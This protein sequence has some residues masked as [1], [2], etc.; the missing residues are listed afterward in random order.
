MY[1][2]MYLALFNQAWGLYGKILTEVMSEYR[3]NEVRSVHTTEVKI[4][5]YRLTKFGK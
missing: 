2:Q 3:P 4:L 5:P 1:S